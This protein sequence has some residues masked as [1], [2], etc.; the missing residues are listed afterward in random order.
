MR[1]IAVGA[2]LLIIACGG[3]HRSGDNSDAPVINCMPEGA[4]Q[5]QGSTWQTCQGGQWVT[6]VDCPTACADMLGCVQCFPGNNFCFNGNVVACDSTGTPGQVVQMCMGQ[7]TCSN[8]QCVD[9]CAD[10]AANRSYIGCEYWA[11]DLDNAVEVIAAQAGG[12]C[13]AYGIPGLIPVT[14]AACIK[15]Q[16]PFTYTAGTPPG[17]GTLANAIVVQLPAPHFAKQMVDLVDR[18]HHEIQSRFYI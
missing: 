8:A 16:G 11:V 2:A 13:T 9:A 18:Q 5:C 3:S 17:F 6:A 4:N 14:T 12:S 7:D 10:A 1:S 15:T